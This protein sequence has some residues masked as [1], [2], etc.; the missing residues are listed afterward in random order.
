MFRRAGGRPDRQPSTRNLLGKVFDYKELAAL[1]P[2]GLS[3]ASARVRE[4]IAMEFL[5]ALHRPPSRERDEKV[6][7][8]KAL[9][10]TTRSSTTASDTGGVI[11]FDLCLPGTKPADA[12]RQLWLDHAIVHETSD[13][14]QTRVL[15]HLQ[16][17]KSASLSMP[18]KRAEGEKKGRF[19]G[20]MRVAE[21]LSKEGFLG[22]SPFFLFPVVS[23]RG[24]MNA[25]MIKLLKWISDRYKDTLVP[26][27]DRLDGETRGALLGKFRSYLKRAVCFAVLRATAMALHSQGR[28]EVRRP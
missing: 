13:S 17:G 15:R 20:L 18:F 8:I 23:T 1:F 28:H 11:R 12:P 26:A 2:G 16:A 6:A 7:R 4:G 24:C 5:T 22:F 9:F 27:P 25:D 14:Y 3:L 19:G 10:P 21:R